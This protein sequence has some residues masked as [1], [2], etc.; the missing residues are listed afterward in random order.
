MYPE[1]QLLLYNTSNIH[2]YSVA[3]KG[4]FD[5]LSDGFKLNNDRVSE[6]KVLQDSSGVQCFTLIGD[7]I[8][9]RKSVKV[10]TNSLTF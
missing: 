2:T 10:L 7:K 3:A 6:I 5:V 4:Q 8:K 9:K 1:E